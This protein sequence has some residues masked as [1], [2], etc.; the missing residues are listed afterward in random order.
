MKKTHTFLL[1]VAGALFVGGGSAEAY[2]GYGYRANDPVK[3]DHCYRSPA[4]DYAA[5]YYAMGPDRTRHARN[6]RHYRGK[7]RHHTADCC[8][9]GNVKGRASP[10]K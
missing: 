2:V 4:W 9:D 8:C 1:A 5:T 3:V 7:N 10:Y 6:H